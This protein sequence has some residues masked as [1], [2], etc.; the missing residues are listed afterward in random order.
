MRHAK[1]GSART[2][3]SSTSRGL[4]NIEYCSDRDD[5]SGRHS[6][7][8]QKG[9][10][11]ACRSNRPD[12]AEHRRARQGRIDYSGGR[13]GG[14]RESAADIQRIRAQGKRIGVRRATDR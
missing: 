9:R 7:V 4:N 14:D 3:L 12:A 11:E 8:D 13:T 5:A 10:A 1:F 2:A 6:C